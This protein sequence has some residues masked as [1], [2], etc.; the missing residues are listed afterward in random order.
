MTARCRFPLALALVAVVFVSWPQAQSAVRI[1]MGTVVPK[2]SLWDDT[3]QYIR[4]EWQRISNGS[5]QVTIYPGGVLG[6]EVEMVQQ[7]RQGRIQAVGLSSV[8]LSRI[9][10]GV[11]CLQVPMMLRS[12]EELDY[13]RDRMATALE[14][15]MAAQ[16]FVV[17]NWADGGWV[18]LF[19]KVAARTPDEVRA[20][21]LFTAAGDPETERLYK[22]FG[23]RAVPLSMTDVTTSLQTGMID[24]LLTVPLFAQLDG[25]YKLTRYMLD[26]KWTPLVGG[27]VISRHTWEQIPPAQRPALLAAARSAGDRLRDRI[28]ALGDASIPEM[29]KRGLTVTRVD[30]ATLETWQKVAESAY[31]QLRGRYC[32]ADLFDEVL[33]LRDEFRRSARVD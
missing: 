23:F 3:L 27:T 13:V 29:E 17:L 26:V 18:H 6:G 2:G 16:G 28:R 33:R 11:S 24:A 10:T 15:R 7:V 12:Y 9:D 8:G 4:Q 14:A 30:A 25:T 5:V 1:R 19:S 32:P 22:E 21:K 31:P 20:L